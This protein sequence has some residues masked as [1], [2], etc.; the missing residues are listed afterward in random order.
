MDSFAVSTTVIVK[1]E[2][3]DGAKGHVLDR[4]NRWIVEPPF[5]APYP[6]GS[7]LW[8]RFGQESSGSEPY[9]PSAPPGMM[10][11][12]D[13]AAVTVVDGELWC[14]P[15][16]PYGT[17]DYANF[18]PVTAPEEQGFLDSANAIFGTTFKLDDFDGR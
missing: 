17:V 2:S 12:I 5:E 8:Y 11:E 18:G 16:D 3:W 4:L 15:L 10:V 1:A 14:A 13:G 7:L 6:D 9:L